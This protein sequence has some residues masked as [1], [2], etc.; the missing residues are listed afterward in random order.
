MKLLAVF[1]VM[2]AALLCW[3]GAALA[4]SAPAEGG[5]RSLSDWLVRMHEAARRRAYTGT[6]V[7]LSDGQ[8]ASSRIW[9]VC[10][11]EK[12]IERVESLTGTPRATF[13]RNEEVITFA[14]ETRV[15]VT[16]RREGLNMFPHLLKAPGTSVEQFYAM[17]HE[18][19]ERVAGFEADVLL[20]R[21]NDRLRHGYRIWSE[22]KTGL[23]I[24]LQTLDQDERV[25]EQAAFSELQLDA[26]VSMDKLARMMGNT[27]GYTVRSAGQIKTTPAAEGWRLKTQV[28]GFAW[29]SC[30]RRPEAERHTVQWVF[31]DG[32]ASVSLFLET[33][34]ANRHLKEGA[35][36]LGATQMLTRRIE[37]ARH[38]RWWLT[39]VGEVPR[40]T[41]EAFA[42]AVE[43][44]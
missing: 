7:V 13:R 24:R 43:R 40:R 27:D 14:P 30:Y 26:P 41:L 32:L 38:Q 37:D 8:M 3:G 17:R 5:E 39:A 18:G 23:V 22:R 12:Q 28:P 6:F 36:S 4:Q 19:R 44:K 29:V 35:L 25:L 34:D 10:D 9:H 42:Q 33:F 31:T 1:R 11:G 20:L 2:L 15:A 21:P 16:E